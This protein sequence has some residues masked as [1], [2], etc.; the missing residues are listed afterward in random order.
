MFRSALDSN[1]IRAGKI[2]RIEC[3]PQNTKPRERER[4]SAHATQLSSLVERA[5]G[6]PRSMAA[7]GK[8]KHSRAC[9]FR[10]S[11][12]YYYYPRRCER[13]LLFTMR[14]RDVPVIA[15]DGLA[16]INVIHRIDRATCRLRLTTMTMF[17]V[18]SRRI[19]RIFFS[20]SFNSCPFLSDGALY[21]TS[22]NYWRN[23]VAFRYYKQRRIK[24]CHE[25][26]IMHQT[27]GQTR[28]PACF[29]PLSYVRTKNPRIETLTSNIALI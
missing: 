9:Y 13:V 7:Y 3:A 10:T 16:A 21:I 14:T 24:I 4:R 6:A 1:E 8:R 28:S 11:R 19:H 5:S 25:S 22:V 26:S 12:H 18:S 17:S 15:I 20:S 29:I 2:V 27:R 23:S